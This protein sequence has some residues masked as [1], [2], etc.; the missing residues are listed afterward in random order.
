[1]ERKDLYGSNRM[2]MTDLSGRTIFSYDL[3]KLDEGLNDIVL[4]LQELVPWL[5]AGIYFI[6]LEHESRSAGQ[7]KFVFAGN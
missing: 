5:K 6:S 7:M 4:N 1:M 3:D 2:V